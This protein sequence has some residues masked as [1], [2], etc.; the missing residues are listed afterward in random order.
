MDQKASV[1]VH[2]LCEN[3]PSEFAEYLA[4]VRALKFEEEP[5]YAYLRKIFRDLFIRNGFEYDNVFDWTIKR[6]LECSSRQEEEPL[7]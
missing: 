7:E 1:D 4:H 6:Y 3:A 2:E 5:K